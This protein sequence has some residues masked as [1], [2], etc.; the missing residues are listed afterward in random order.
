VYQNLRDSVDSWLIEHH[1]L[2]HMHLSITTPQISLIEAII[3]AMKSSPLQ[4]QFPDPQD[5]ALAP[6][7]L[8]PLQPLGLSGKGVPCANDQI[9]L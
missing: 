4:Y 6:Y 3:T 5:A 8:L 1:L 7:E 9:Y 2:H